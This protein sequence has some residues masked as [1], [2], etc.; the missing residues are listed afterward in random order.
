MHLTK[1]VLGAIGAG[2]LSLGTAYSAFFGLRGLDFS[3]Y[4]TEVY[5][6]S[7]TQGTQPLSSCAYDVIK[8]VRH[9][10]LLG[11]ED[12]LRQESYYD[13]NFDGFLD[14]YRKRTVDANDTSYTV[15]GDK[16]FYYRFGND[17]LFR[18]P[19]VVTDKDGSI[20]V[21]PRNPRYYKQGSVIV[22]DH[23]Y[24]NRVMT[25]EEERELQ[26]EFD[27]AVSNLPKNDPYRIA[28]GK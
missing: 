8:E 1:K 5:G 15:D 3:R 20:I 11:F 14:R 12:T 21:V 9:F 28:I 2:V 17:E 18:Q 22:E 25:V 26:R 24:V 10:G 27:E 19:Q 23:G 7:Q 16:V 4:Y 6:C 13:E